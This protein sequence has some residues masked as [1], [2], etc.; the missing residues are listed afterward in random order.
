M[1]Y[2]GQ[3]FQIG[4]TS[5]ENSQKYIQRKK[6]ECAT[7]SSNSVKNVPL[8]VEQQMEEAVLHLVV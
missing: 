6:P 2:T 1:K 5:K 4:S 7:F 3:H 8:E